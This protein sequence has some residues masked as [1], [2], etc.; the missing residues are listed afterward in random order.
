MKPVDDT[1][2]MDGP[3]GH[4]DRPGDG[5]G[6]PSVQQRPAPLALGARRRPGPRRRRAP[7]TYWNH[8]Q[9]NRHVSVPLNPCVRAPAPRHRR[10]SLAAAAC[11]RDDAR[12]DEAQKFVAYAVKP[13][14][15][16]ISAFATARLPLSAAAIA[17][18]ETLL[19][20]DGHEV[21]RARARRRRES[22]RRDRRGRIGQR[23]HH[24]SRRPHPHQRPRRCA[25]ARSRALDRDLLPQRRDRR[26]GAALPASRRCARSIAAKRSTATSSRSPRPGRHRRTCASRIRSSSR[27]ARRCRSRSAAGRR[28]LDAAR[29]RSGAAADR[30][31]R[32]AVARARRFRTDAHRRVDLL[33]RLSG[34]GQQ[35]RRSHRRLALARQRS[36]GD[37][38]SRHDHG[39]Q[40]RRRQHAGAAVE[41]GHLPRQLRRAGRESRRRS[42]RHL[43]VGT[44][45]AGAD[46]V[47]RADQRRAQVSR[48]TRSVPVN[49]EGEF[50]QHYRAA[51]DAA[52]TASGC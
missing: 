20:A 8:Q 14:V 11:R 33:G 31:Q 44:H 6:S 45:D 21:A 35:H 25:D 42:D 3:A 7:G 17:E 43:H 29:D 40:A 32:S 2:R 36:R 47:P 1:L 18:I 10:R 48:A 37:V 27:T 28:A 13:A 26:A 15:V 30:A 23:L 52:R 12:V 38:Q 9:H 34:R 5:C 16:R 46:Q 50:N 39:D 49:A 24:P 41:R 22:R 19:R 4:R 51:L